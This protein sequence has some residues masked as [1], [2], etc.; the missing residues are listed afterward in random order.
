[1][2]VSTGQRFF[3]GRRWLAWPFRNF[4]GVCDNP[5]MLQE[6]RGLTERELASIADLERRVV[7]AD[8]GRLKLAWGTLR[9]RPGNQV[10]DWLWWEGGELV[11]FAGLYTFAPPLELAG[12]V[13]PAYRRRGVAGSLLDAAIA[14]AAAR[15]RDRL[16]LVAPRSTTTGAAFAASRGATLEHSEHFLVLDSD[17]SV[18]SPRD[19]VSVRPA[20]AADADAVHRLLVGAFGAEATGPGGAHLPGGGLVVTVDGTAIGTVHVGTQ[21]DHASISGFVVTPKLRGQGIGRS[22]LRTVCNRAFAMGAAYVTLEV[23][24]DNEHALG[25]YTSVGFEPRATE[26]YFEL[27]L[28]RVVS[29][30]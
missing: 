20:T 8:G 9:H 27:L 28:D 11:G 1:M 25:L 23:A 4:Y 16:L 21:D 7:A 26:D 30:S 12:M 2:R 3:G 5:A 15:R 22:A 6:A 24:A 13:D 19:D 17:P 14:V 10:D 29:P 18:A